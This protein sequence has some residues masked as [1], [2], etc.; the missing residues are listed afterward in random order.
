[1]LA[2]LQRVGLDRGLF[3]GS[4]RVWLVVGTTA[5]LLR[6]ARRVSRP[7]DD[8][9]FRQVLGPGETLQI[10]HT[11]LTRAGGPATGRRRR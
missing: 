3:A 8:V 2:L 4:N 11:L 7:T 10:D 6:T 5:W 1:V 9:V